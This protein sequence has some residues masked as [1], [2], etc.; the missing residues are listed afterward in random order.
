MLL[1]LTH[2]DFKYFFYFLKTAIDFRLLSWFTAPAK[3]FSLQENLRFKQS[4]TVSA[5]S[6]EHVTQLLFWADQIPLMTKHSNWFFCFVLMALIFQPFNLNLRYIMDKVLKV[7]NC[8][9]YLL[10]YHCM[11]DT[12]STNIVINS[13][14]GWTPLPVGLMWTTVYLQHTFNISESDIPNEHARTLTQVTSSKMTKYKY[15]GRR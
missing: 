9:Q 10:C 11:T 4:W 8:C 7:L 5:G 3:L 13:K 12:T 1:N 2:R 15:Q 6:S 14:Q